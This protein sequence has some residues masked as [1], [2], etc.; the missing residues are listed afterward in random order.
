MRHFL[1]LPNQAKAPTPP[2]NSCNLY[3]KTQI[4]NLQDIKL[5]TLILK[6]YSEAAVG[7]QMWPFLPLPNQAK[8]LSLETLLSVPVRPSGPN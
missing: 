6:P 8:A 7:L 5:Q 1:P 2:S 3:L 4:S